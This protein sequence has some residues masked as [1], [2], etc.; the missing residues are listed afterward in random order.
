MTGTTRTRTEL[1]SRYCLLARSGFEFLCHISRRIV[2]I[3]PESGL[4]EAGSLSGRQGLDVDGQILHL[5]PAGTIAVGVV[6]AFIHL[7]RHAK[8]RTVEDSAV[9]DLLA[10]AVAAHDVSMHTGFA[11]RVGLDGR[12]ILNVNCRH[13]SF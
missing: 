5:L 7:E 10:F 4:A 8:R 13:S 3:R 9:D 2:L 1:Q 6:G 12:S 11:L